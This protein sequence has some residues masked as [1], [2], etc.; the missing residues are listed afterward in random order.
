MS[1]L[2]NLNCSGTVLELGT[3]SPDRAQLVG[4]TQTTAS[5]L[6]KRL[7]VAELD[8][9]PPSPQQNA[10]DEELDTLGDAPA[11]ESSYLLSDSM[12]KRRRSASAPASELGS[13]VSIGIA[14]V[15]QLRSALRDARAEAAA[16]REEAE[17]LKTELNELRERQQ[18]S[19]RVYMEIWN[20]LQHKLVNAELQAALR[21]G[22]PQRRTSSLG[23]PRLSA[24]PTES[25]TATAM[26]IAADA[27]VAEAA[28]AADEEE[29]AAEADPEQL[30]R[31]NKE[32]RRELAASRDLCEFLQQQ[33]QAVQEAGSET[34]AALESRVADLRKMLTAARA[35]SA[36]QDQLQSA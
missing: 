2:E 10:P 23:G 31:E 1:G 6:F 33:V 4:T 12:Q 34:I 35:Q 24:S 17:S 32:L 18:D 36:Q 14:D 8:L 26:D 25:E 29:A 9:N 19:S 15:E 20:D 28:P 3:S 13:D 5:P 30:A 11:R 22:R 16:A 27:V 21:A 7:H